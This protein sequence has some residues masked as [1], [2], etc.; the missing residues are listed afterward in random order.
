[1]AMPGTAA[2]AMAAARSRSTFQVVIVRRVI[3][4]CVRCG[5]QIRIVSVPGRAL[6]A[7][8]VQK[9]IEQVRLAGHDLDDQLGGTRAGVSSAE[10]HLLHRIG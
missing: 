9:G 6:L 10:Q 2:S 4:R 1:M 5:H 7:N 3:V 8:S